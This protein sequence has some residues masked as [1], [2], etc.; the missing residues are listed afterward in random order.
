MSKQMSREGMGWQEGSAGGC[1]TVTAYTSKGHK[2]GELQ[3]Y[4][5]DKQDS[6]QRICVKRKSTRMSL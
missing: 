6:T 4:V 3:N 5:K 1:W 2:I